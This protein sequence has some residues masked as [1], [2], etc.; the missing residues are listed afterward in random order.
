MDY[1]GWWK[2]L[3]SKTS[4]SPR[5]VLFP[6]GEE[7][8]V[9]SAA[10]FLARHSLARPVLLGDQAR[11]AGQAKVLGLSLAGCESWDQR[12]D[13]RRQE[14]AALLL[15]RRRSKGM[16]EDEALRQMDDPLFFGAL[17]LKT[18]AVQAVVAGA[19]KTTSETVRAG[20]SCLGLAKEAET[21]FGLFLLECPHAWGGGR[22]V[23]LADAA[24]MPD[25]SPRA[26]AAIG[27]AAAGVARRILREEPRVAYLSFSTLG[28]AAHALAE[29]V[30]QAVSLARQRNPGVAMEGE[31]QGD[32]ALSSVVATQKGVTTP[33]A[34]QA[35]VLVAPDLNT[36][37]IAYKLV[38][39]LGGARVAGPWICGLSAP[40]SDLSRGASDREIVDSTL[41][42]LTGSPA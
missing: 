23:L 24:V 13:T 15:E 4:G 7:G 26:L 14:F 27:G 35:N 31:W 32:A 10:D 6:E 3:V 5:S 30:R 42:L 18:G 2:R 40:F 11:I 9:L 12:K 34:G 16:T 29:R 19:V 25:P 21:C 17:A 20:L 1:G 36:G 39:Y 37:N 41:F 33:W 22:Q 8:R 38:Q 28:S